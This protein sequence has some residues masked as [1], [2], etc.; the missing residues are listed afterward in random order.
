MR[1]DSDPIVTAGVAPVPGMG[2]V[3]GPATHAQAIALL[4]H[5]MAKWHPDSQ[6]SES[7]RASIA[8]LRAAQ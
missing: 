7:V 4:E 2:R 8:V 5:A 1:N 6:P 3:G